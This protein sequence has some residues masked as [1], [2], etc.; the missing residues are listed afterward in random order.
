[1]GTK[2]LVIYKWPGEFSFHN[3]T[4]AFLKIINHCSALWRAS[5]N[6]FAELLSTC[7][8]IVWNYPFSHDKLSPALNQLFW[9]EQVDSLILQLHRFLLLRLFPRFLLLFSR[10]L[11]HVSFSPLF[12]TLLS[13]HHIVLTLMVTCESR[14]IFSYISNIG[15][16]INL[17]LSMWKTHDL[18]CHI[19][20]EH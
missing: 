1:M 9:H 8:S 13:S 2:M 12:A 6:D 3:T 18:P 10:I 7:W 17:D 16:Q 14:F 15:K 4:Y 11:L 20:F 5:L 19:F